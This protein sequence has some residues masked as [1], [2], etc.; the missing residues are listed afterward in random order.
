ME[1]G[2]GGGGGVGGGDGSTSEFGPQFQGAG[3]VIVTTTSD[4]A[5]GNTSSIT[6]LLGDPGDR[7]LDFDV[8]E[9][10]LDHSTTSPIIGRQVPTRLASISLGADNAYD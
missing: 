2:K 4:I 8:R 10:I 9:A 3:V 7:W 1:K 6:A 5:D